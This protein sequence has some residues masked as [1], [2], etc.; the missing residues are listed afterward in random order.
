MKQIILKTLQ[1]YKY[2]CLV[3]GGLVVPSVML[4]VAVYCINI[5]NHEHLE[6]CA[7]L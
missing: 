7:L 4:K 3:T 1:H 5:S 2:P 6:E